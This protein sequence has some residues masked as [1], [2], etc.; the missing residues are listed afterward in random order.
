MLRILLRTATGLV[1]I[2]LCGCAAPP[3]AHP[4]RSASVA[5]T[6]T[7]TGLRPG[8]AVRVPRFGTVVFRNALADAAMRVTVQR[9]LAGS[10]PCSTMLGF[11]A[12]G[13]RSVAD[14]IA[15]PGFAA[16]CFHDPGSFPFTVEIAGRVLR[17][18]VEVAAEVPR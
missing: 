13:E 11:A 18:T 5:V 17:G 2:G 14:G 12:D 1:G 9:P 3:G 6:V 15:G 8:G 10:L 16:L 7:D 4:D